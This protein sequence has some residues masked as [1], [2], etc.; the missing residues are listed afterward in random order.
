MTNK[1]KILLAQ[2]SSAYSHSLKEVFANPGIAAQIK[3]GPSHTPW[4]CLSPKFALVQ[5]NQSMHTDD[6]QQ[7]TSCR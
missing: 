2:A 3:V 1:D 7:T 4:C 6:R 5:N